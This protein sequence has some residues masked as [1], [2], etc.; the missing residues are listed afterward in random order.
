MLWT[1]LAPA[2]LEGGG[3]PPEVFGVRYELAADEGFKRIVRRGAIEALPEEAHTVHA[4]IGGLQPETPYWYRFKWGTAVSRVG[5]TRTAP[6]PGTTPAAMRFAFVSC[7]NYSNGFY[8]AY[9]DIAAQ[10]ELELVVHLGDYI[11]E[12]PGLGV[13]RVRDHVPARELFSLADYRTRHALYKTDPDLQEAHAAH[14]FLMTWDDHEFKDNYADLDLDPNQPLETVAERRAAAYLAY[15]EHAPLSRSRKPVGKDMN[16][17]RRASW[18]DLATF[19]VLDTRQYRSDQITQCTQA[20]RDPVSGYCPEQLNPARTLLGAA[21]REWLFEGLSAAP[22]SGWN[23]LANQ[24]GFAAQDDLPQPDRRRFFVDSWDGYVADRQRV[25][26]FLK[27][28]KLSNTVVITGDKHQNSVRNVRGELHGHR[29]AADHHGVRRHLDQ[30]RGRQAGRHHDARR[31]SQQPAH[32]VRGLPPRLRA[33]HAQAGALD[34]R[35]PRRRHRAPARERDDV[36]HRLVRGR[37]RQAGRVRAER[38]S[39]A[40]VTRRLQ[41]RPDDP[42]QVRERDAA[43]SAPAPD[44][45]LELQRSAGNAAVARVL[46]REPRPNPLLTYR[47]QLAPD[48]EWPS[49]AGSPSRRPGSGSRCSTARSRCPRSSIASGAACPRRPAPRPTRSARA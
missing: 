12:G 40:R 26:D 41:H 25:L 27:E 35:V 18:G 3:L 4:E 29:R 31:R 23:V 45:L 14:P 34:E 32:P 44:S 10:Q 8:P 49:T 43:A 5:R 16:L 2:P 11:Y 20:Q 17:Y 39:V 21:Q 7:Q 38:R 1:R 24:V 28:H 36:D 15:W 19:H 13:D 46:A 37:A 22:P 48:V 47:P 6:L 33:R 42:E 9:G 30:Q